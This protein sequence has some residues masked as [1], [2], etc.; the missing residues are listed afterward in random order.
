M[1]IYI[2]DNRKILPK[3]NLKFDCVITSP[4]YNFGKDYSIYKDN[5]SEKEYINNLK[6]VAEC[7]YEKLSD[8][9]T[10]FLSL[11]WKKGNP[12][13]AEKIAQCFISCGFQ[14]RERIIWMNTCPSYR[15]HQEKCLNQQWENIFLFSKTEQ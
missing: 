5:L 1:K 6:I 15:N 14:L 7:L 11:G 9:G 3:L 10:I 2:G 13:L 12:F 4:P 8:N